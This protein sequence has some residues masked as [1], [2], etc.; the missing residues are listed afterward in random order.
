MKVTH[1]LEKRKSNKT[2]QSYYCIV[3]YLGDKEVEQIFLSRPIQALL[4]YTDSK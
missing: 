2:N 4:D 1:K 3:F